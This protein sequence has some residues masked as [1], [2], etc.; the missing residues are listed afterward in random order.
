MSRSYY[1]EIWIKNVDK[2]HGGF[3]LNPIDKIWITMIEDCKKKNILKIKE[4][5][6]DEKKDVVNYSVHFIMHCSGGTSAQI[7]LARIVEDLNKNEGVLVNEAHSW[8]LHGD[9]T[10]ADINFKGKVKK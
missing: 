3:D 4:H 8:S 10:K 2:Y 6:D 1:T 7:N 5:S 9:I